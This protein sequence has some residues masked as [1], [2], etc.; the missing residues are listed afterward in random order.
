MPSISR[1]I[2]IALLP[3]VTAGPV[4]RQ[5]GSSSG[6]GSST[7]NGLDGDCKAV[8]VIFARGTTE[9]GNVG[10]SAGP[11]FFEALATKLGDGKLAV[12]GVEYAADVAGIMQGGDKA[13]TEKMAS[14]V[15]QA[16]TKCPDTHVVV[17]GYS[18]G[19]MLVHNAAK[20]LSADVTGKIAASVT[21]G[22]P[23]QKQAVQGV[24][25][26]R[27][28]VFCHSGDSVCLGTGIITAAHLTYSQDAE[29]AAAFVVTA[30]GN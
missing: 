4:I 20:S 30:I 2:L 8:T 29:A 3:F 5:F 21:F 19:A 1:A 23:Y 25:A 28:K 13:G 10:T 17:S 27:T 11:P 22:D 16:M 12:Q 7:Q 6:F 9:T 14:L 18:Q 24:S 15:Q 26:D